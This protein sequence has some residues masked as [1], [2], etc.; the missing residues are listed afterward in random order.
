[1]FRSQERDTAL[2]GRYAEVHPMS[3]LPFVFGTCPKNRPKGSFQRWTSGLV[4]KENLRMSLKVKG[5]EAVG[6]KRMSGGVTRNVTRSV[7]QNPRGEKSSRGDRLST[8]SNRR[9]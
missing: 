9:C 6:M 4:P 3:D 8:R 1:M 5:R 2:R 7:E